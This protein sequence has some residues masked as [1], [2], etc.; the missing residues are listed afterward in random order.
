MTIQFQLLYYEPGL[1]LVGY[2]RYII[3]IPLKVSFKGQKKLCIT[4]ALYFYVSPLQ[5]AST[6]ALVPKS[7]TSPFIV[8]LFSNTNPASEG[9]L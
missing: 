2:I 7:S 9:M 6:S 5:N 8:N 3:L 1:D 4:E